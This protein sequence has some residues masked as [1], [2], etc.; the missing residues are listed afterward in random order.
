MMT[1]FSTMPTLDNLKKD[2]IIDKRVDTHAD[3]IFPNKSDYRSI[4][5]GLQNNLIPTT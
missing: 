2:S 1:A 3:N 5:A 4:M